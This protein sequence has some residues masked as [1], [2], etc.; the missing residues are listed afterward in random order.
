MIPHFAKKAIDRC[1]GYALVSTGETHRILAEVCRESAVT[2][3][4]NEVAAQEKNHT[5]P[6]KFEDEALEVFMN[7]D[8]H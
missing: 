5:G 8:L 6:K 7:K 3:T 4:T 1:W 2:D